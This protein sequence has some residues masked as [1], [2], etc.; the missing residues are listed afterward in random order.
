MT[1]LSKPRIVCAAIQLIG[2]LVVPS[3]RH[4]DMTMRL[5]LSSTKLETLGARQGFIDQH[6][7]FYDREQAWDIAKANDQ[8]RRDEG[9][10]TGT[11][12]SEHLY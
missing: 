9:K 12:Y 7:Q 3:A 10:C 6:G 2:G 5:V 11:L 4:F 1:E 8:I